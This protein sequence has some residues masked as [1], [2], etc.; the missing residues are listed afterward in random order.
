M[1]LCKTSCT[2]TSL[3]ICSH[4]DFWCSSTF[5]AENWFTV[6]SISLLTFHSFDALLNWT[7][8]CIYL[9][10][11][12]CVWR[13]RDGSLLL[14]SLWTSVWGK[15]HYRTKLSSLF[16][17]KVHTCRPWYHIISV[18][19]DYNQLNCTSRVRTKCV[20]LSQ[21]CL[22]GLATVEITVFLNKFNDYYLLKEN[23]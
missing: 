20:C 19:A 10:V 6:R 21:V 1:H 13:E 17:N 12:V 3:E 22:S 4:L 18:V 14:W 9:C 5:Q 2:H 7:I 11:W 15:T 8:Y 16:S 23:K